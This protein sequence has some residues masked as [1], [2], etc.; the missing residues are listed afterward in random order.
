MSSHA[1]QRTSVETSPEHSRMPRWNSCL[2]WLKPLSMWTKTA[3]KTARRGNLP[4]F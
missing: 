1:Q 4:G 3:S 2:T